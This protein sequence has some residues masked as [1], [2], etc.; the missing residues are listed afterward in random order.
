VS[1]GTRGTSVNDP[2]L[3]DGALPSQK[4]GGHLGGVRMKR[5]SRLLWGA[6]LLVGGLSAP[7]SAQSLG[8]A[9]PTGC[10]PSTGVGAGPSAG[11][12]GLPSP[13]TGEVGGLGVSPGAALPGRTLPPSPEAQLPGLSPQLNATRPGGGL[14][15]SLAGVP[16]A[17]PYGAGAPFTGPSVPLPTIEV[18]GLSTGDT[19]FGAPSLNGPGSSSLGAGSTFTEPGLGPSLGAPLPAGCP[20]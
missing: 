12:V 10:P 20:R 2:A 4:F 11:S 18:P 5:Q 19:G 8:G 17:D 16:G 15:G 9:G 1:V 6:L 13:G 3:K 14:S 7:A